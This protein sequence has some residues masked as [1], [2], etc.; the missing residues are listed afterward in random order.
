M[1]HVSTLKNHQD[2]KI[3]EI[4]HTEGT[5]P[6]FFNTDMLLLPDLVYVLHNKQY[7]LETAT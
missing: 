7:G 6:L 1:Q 2:A 3:L 4:K 5:Q